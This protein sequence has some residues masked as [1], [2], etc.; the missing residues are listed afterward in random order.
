MWFYSYA[1]YYGDPKKNECNYF[2]LEISNKI[3]W[4]K[5]SLYQALNYKYNR[6]NLNTPVQLKYI[7]LPSIASIAEAFS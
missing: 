5:W 4:Y 3:L 1:S 2:S 6:N 7:Y